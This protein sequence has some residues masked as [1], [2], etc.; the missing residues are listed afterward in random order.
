H[1]GRK[2]GVQQ[3]LLGGAG[4]RAQRFAHPAQRSHSR[5]D[6]QAGGTDLRL[7]PGRLARRLEIPAGGGRRYTGAGTRPGN[8]TESSTTIIRNRPGK[9][10]M[11]TISRRGFLGMTAAGAVLQAQDGQRPI[12]RVKVDMVVLSF[13]VTDS[14]GHYV[15][16]LK[17]TD[18]RIFEDDILKQGPT[19]SDGDQP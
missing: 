8:R 12:F 9:T 6:A 4:R 18:L 14:K 11:T 15:Y 19:I 1:H 2:L 3:P 5:M 10:I 7:A 13:Q 16:G 17:P